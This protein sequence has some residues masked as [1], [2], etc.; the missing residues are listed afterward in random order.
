MKIVLVS[1]Y[2]L[3]VYGGVQ[4]QVLAM[5]RELVSRGHEVTVVAPGDTS[6]IAGTTP[7]TVVGLGRVTSVPANGSKAP[8]SLGFAASRQLASLVERVRP[9]VVH[10]HE[11]FAPTMAWATLRRHEVPV[12]ATF[13][14]SGMGPDIT[15]GRA[16]LRRLARGIDAAASVS[17]SAERTALDGYGVATTALFNGLDVARFRTFE[18]TLPATPRLLVVG[19]LEERKGVAIAIR[20]VLAHNASCAPAEHWRL[21]IAGTGPELS[22]LERLAEG[23]P[24]ITFL[25]A[26]G[27]E[28]KRRRL[29][30]ATV[31]LCPALFGESFGLVLL[32]AMAA[33]VP[34]VASDIDGYRQASGGHG[35]LFAPS[36]EGDLC[37]AVEAAMGQTSEESL[38]A[39]KHAQGWSMSALVDQYDVLYANAKAAFESR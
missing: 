20:A 27:D 26:I 24:Y 4:E 10:A 32:E 5:H 39:L 17:P 33:G 25:G 29:R 16:L 11:P 9:D 12:V 36:N 38:A 13:H 31:A 37:R 8:V 2:A 34:V 3:S 23:S 22:A 7:A 35:Y 6:I 18:R 14:R 21:D 15:L 1:P 19:R 28:E 30:E